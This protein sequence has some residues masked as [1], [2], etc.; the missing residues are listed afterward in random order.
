M[1]KAIGTYMSNKSQSNTD[2]KVFLQMLD[3]YE[4]L[5]LANYVE[6]DES[7]M[8]FGNT[9]FKE[10]ENIKE[11]VTSMSDNL[12]N[13]YFNLYHWCK[14]ELFDIIAVNEALKQKDKIQDKI[15]KNEKKKRS[16]QDDLDNVTQGRKTLKTLLKKDTDAGTMVTK[17]E[18]V[19]SF[20][21]ID[22]VL[23][24]QRNRKFEHLARYHHDLLG[25]A[26]HSTI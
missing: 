6:G 12:K 10:S 11:A 24:R 18:N 2:Y 23:D 5:N 13:P 26:D 21:L 22:F 3:K 9:Q 19:S 16:K 8:V 17:I 4:E 14:G 20:P 25:S 15:G 7:K 1:I